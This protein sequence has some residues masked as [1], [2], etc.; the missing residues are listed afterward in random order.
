MGLFLNVTQVI[1][2][3]NELGVEDYD[4]HLRAIEASVTLLARKVA[5]DLN[6]EYT[7]TSLGLGGFLSG[8]KP[9]TANQTCPDVLK[10]CDPSSD[11]ATGEEGGED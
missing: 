4:D 2:T 7:D 5:R 11:W 6:V 1:E 10:I 9:S 8:F 3:A